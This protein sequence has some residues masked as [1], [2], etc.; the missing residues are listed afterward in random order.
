MLLNLLDRRIGASL[1][2]L[3]RNAIEEWSL[4]EA[5]SIG[6][7][8][9]GLFSRRRRRVSKVTCH[10]VVVLPGWNVVAGVPLSVGL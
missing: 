7:V 4:K 5:L 10:L 9:Q 2:E 8:T 1:G 3:P 6:T